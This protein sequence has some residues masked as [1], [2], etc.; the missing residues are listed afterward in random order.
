M[1]GEEYL[2]YFKQ[3][4]TKVV[5]PQPLKPF[6]DMFEWLSRSDIKLSIS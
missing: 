1:Y 5:F 4:S 6:R 2:T 3:S